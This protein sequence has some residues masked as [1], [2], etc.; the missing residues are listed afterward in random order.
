MSARQSKKTIQVIS[1][2]IFLIVMAAVTVLSIPLIRLLT[3]EEGRILL[4]EKVRSLGF[5]GYGAFLA[6]QIIQV[7]IAIIPGEP[8]E[9]IGGI[10]FGW[11]GGTLLC[12]IGSLIGTVCVFYLVKKIGQ[13]IVDAFVSEE[14]L[15]HFKF[16]NDEKKLETVVFILFLI[17][18]TPKDA[19]T[20]LI[21]LTKIHPA[22]FF[23]LATLARFPSIISSA[24]VGGNIGSGNFLTSIIVFAAT[25]AVGLVG[26]YLNEKFTSK[27]KE[28]AGKIKEKLPHMKKEEK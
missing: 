3:S 11:L 19:L 16:L 12:V 8:V 20:Y 6:L 27:L 17:P 26:I 2:I 9:I 10:L 18:G 21:P 5:W 7:V 15:Q 4:E 13:P 14:K 1:V 23:F 28:K 22:K 25:I 24:I